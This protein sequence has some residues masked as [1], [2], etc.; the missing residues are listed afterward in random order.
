MATLA[1]L[2]HLAQPFLGLAERPLRAAGLDL[3]ERRLRE[4]D[5]L[6]S[7]G[8]VDG[9][10]TFGGSESVLDIDQ[11]PLL[12]AEAALLRDAVAAGVPVLAICLGGQV[13][14]HALGGTV[15]RLPSRTVA[16]VELEALP[17]AREDAVFSALGSPVS[18]LQWNEDAFTL[19]PSG[20]ELLTGATVGVA[21]F[22]AGPCAWGVQFHPDVDRAALEGWYERYGGWLAQAG[23]VE[24][25]ARA[26]DERHLAAHAEASERLFTA[27]AR[28]VGGRGR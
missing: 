3:D 23:V 13:L 5:A 9:I 2:H 14:S 21:A 4:G 20:T 28:V 12:Q 17:A 8:E 1:C 10:L 22:R 27:F 15:R 6:P 26:A 7:L 25:A 24:D 18:V 11:D 19:P 16:W